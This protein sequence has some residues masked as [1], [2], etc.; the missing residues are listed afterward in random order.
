[1]AAIQKAV[2]AAIERASGSVNWREIVARYE[3]PNLRRSLW[4]VANSVIPYFVLWY[5]MIRLVDT[6]YPLTLALAVITGG[7]M[8]RIFIIFH[9]CGHGSFFKSQRANTLLG[10]ILGVLTFTPFDHWK[11]EHAI[12]HATSADLDRRGTGDVWT[13]TVQEY[14]EAPWWKKV[15]YSTYRNPLILLIIGPL[16][17]FLIAQRFANPK[18]GRRE[19][20]SVLFTN[21]AVLAMVSLAVMIMGLRT[22]LLIQLPVLVFGGMAGVW[23]FYVQHQFEEGHWVRHPEWDYFTAAIKG[24]SFYK[25]PQVLQWFT[26]NIGLHHIHHLSPRIPNY[27]LQ[28]CHSENALFQQVAPVTMLTSLKSLI[29]RFWDEER[30]KFVW[31]DV[32]WRRVASPLPQTTKSV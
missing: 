17:I 11:H 7:F 14:R 22:Y 5:L 26:G 16:F 2:S 3:N 19:K 18:F 30:R 12:H 1:M 6:S 24:S 31:Y 13:M 10:R 21:I 9:D 29:F 28:A 15:A 25:L 4:Q 32:L 27:N 8:V 23:M 20:F